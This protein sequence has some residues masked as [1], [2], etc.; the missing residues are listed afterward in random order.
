MTTS[1]LER[2][3]G[4][5]VKIMHP[6]PPRSILQNQSNSWENS[7]LDGNRLFLWA[8]LCLFIVEEKSEISM[9]ISR[10]SFDLQLMKSFDKFAYVDFSNFSGIHKISAGWKFLAISQ[11]SVLINTNCFTRTSRSYLMVT[12]NSEVCSQSI[13]RHTFLL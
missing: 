9:N 4:S 5:G 3:F 8:Q 1:P 7:G 13:H 11:D 2:K 6:H 10:H 12:K